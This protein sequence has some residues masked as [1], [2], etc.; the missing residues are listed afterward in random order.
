MT[1]G[2]SHH[3]WRFARVAATVIVD[4]VAVVTRFTGAD[5]AVPAL[6]RHTGPRTTKRPP[7]AHE[8]AIRIRLTRSAGA[9]GTTARVVGVAAAGR[10]AAAG[11]A[12]ATRVRRAA[13]I[14]LPAKT[15]PWQSPHAPAVHEWV[16]N[17]QCLPREEDRSIPCCPRRTQV[18]LRLPRGPALPHRVEAEA[19]AA[20]E[21]G[22]DPSILWRTG[23]SAS[24]A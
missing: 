21:P 20:A 1:P 10:V 8:R 3:R 6:R 16:P 17:L 9:L 22:K 23:I 15:A 12:L 14:R 19:R 5:D 18:R 7:S 2:R 13:A 24:Q 4:G 11:D